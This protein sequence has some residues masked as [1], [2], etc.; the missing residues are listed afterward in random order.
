[1][2]P[3]AGGCTLLEE[4]HVVGTIGVSGAA[5]VRDEEIARVGAGPFSDLRR[6][7]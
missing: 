7:R 6:P 5:S 4:G 3:L 1:M 2:L